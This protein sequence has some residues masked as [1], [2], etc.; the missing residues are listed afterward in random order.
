MHELL[1]KY[2]NDKNKRTGL[3]HSTKRLPRDYWY[4]FLNCNKPRTNINQSEIGKKRQNYYC[5][6]LNIFVTFIQHS[7]TEMT[8]FFHKA[9]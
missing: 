1:C 6:K 5:I 3:L 8:H 7:M 9:Y 2:L 4:L